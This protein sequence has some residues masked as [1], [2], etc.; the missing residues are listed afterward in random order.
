MKDVCGSA[1]GFRDRGILREI[2]KHHLDP[3][4]SGKMPQV[5]GRP[6]E[7]RYLLPCMGEHFREP[8]TQKSTGSGDEYGH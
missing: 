5:G 7:Y 8:A 2:S 6:G 4:E 1:R 3:C